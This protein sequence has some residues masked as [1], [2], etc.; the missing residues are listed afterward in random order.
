VTAHLLQIKR[1]D[2]SVRRVTRPIRNKPEVGVV[3]KVVIDGEPIRCRIAAIH[4]RP[5]SGAE[6]IDLIEI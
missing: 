5:L 2:K 3:L 1:K 6:D 4:L